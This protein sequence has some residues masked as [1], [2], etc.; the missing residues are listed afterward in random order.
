MHWTDISLETGS[1]ETNIHYRRNNS[2]FKESVQ[3][4]YSFMC[5]ECYN[6][7][8][9]LLLLLQALIVGKIKRA[10]IISTSSLVFLKILKV[11]E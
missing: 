9:S 4:E 11:I 7:I 8:T 1:Y 6:N 10:F 3:C 5:K 2:I